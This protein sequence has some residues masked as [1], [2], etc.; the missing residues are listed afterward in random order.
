VVKGKK[1]EG[2]SSTGIG[3]AKPS[4]TQREVAPSPTGAMAHPQAGSVM[5]HLELVLHS[6]AF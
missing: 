3:L 1:G 6:V 2:S 5:A 4:S